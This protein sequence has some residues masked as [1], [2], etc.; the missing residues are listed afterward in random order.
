MLV[1][2]AWILSGGRVKT[3]RQSME[4]LLRWAWEKE[5]KNSRKEFRLYCFRQVKAH[6][7]SVEQTFHYH[8]STM[9][10]PKS[11]SIVPLRRKYFLPGIIES[12]LFERHGLLMTRLCSV[13]RIYSSV[14]SKIKTWLIMFLLEIINSI[15]FFKFISSFKRGID[16]L[17]LY[18]VLLLYF[19]D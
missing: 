19:C 1:I 15:I 7:L 5:E 8:T 17:F 2:C 6:D 10:N 13:Y 14:H 4:I 18:F 3:F 16:K 12:S 9:Q 11:R